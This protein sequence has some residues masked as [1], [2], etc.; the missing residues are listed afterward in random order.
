MNSNYLYL[1]IDLGAISF[2]FLFSFH[3]KANFSKKW[4]HLWLAILIPATFFL[5]WDEWFT[6]MGVWGFNPDYILG[7]YLFDLPIE[8]VLFFVCI[9]YACVFTYEA[10]GFFSKRDYVKPFTD[11]ITG[12]LV[13]TLSI[14]GFSN[15]DQW[16]T[17]VTFLLFAVFLTLL[18]ALAKPDF[19]G[20]FYL[21]YLFILIPFVLVNGILT[22]TGIENPVV[23]YNDAENLGI[24]IGTI[25]VE[26]TMYG[27]MLILMNVAL[28][29]YFQARERKGKTR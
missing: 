1:I 2:P 27:M 3:P 15:L 10:V 8:E 7:I 26:D 24:R 18:R 20:K 13:L 12:L 17:G 14:V 21:A 9:P 4:K 5:I 22:G 11:I 29:E 25:P 19:L 28:F 23:W 16:Y 6:R